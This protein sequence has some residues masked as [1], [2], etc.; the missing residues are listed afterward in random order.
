MKVLTT[1]LL[2]MKK[3]LL[4]ILFLFPFILFSQSITFKELDREFKIYTNSGQV[5]FSYFSGDNIS[6]NYDGDVTKVGPVRISY[7]YDGKPTKIGSV[8]ISYNYD[9]QVKKIGGLTIYYDYEGRIKRTS[10][11]VK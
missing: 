2:E 10:G 9:G 6:R 8:R 4:L 11:S 7:N 3:F 1:Q 5:E